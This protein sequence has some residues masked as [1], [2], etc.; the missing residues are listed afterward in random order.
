MNDPNRPS[1]RSRL[2]WILAVVVVVAGLVTAVVVSQLRSTTAGPPTTTATTTTALTT[3]AASA[4]ATKPTTTTPAAGSGYQLLWPFADEK[5]AADWQVSYREGGHQPWHLDAGQTAQSF[6]QGYLG[7]HSLDQIT[8]MTVAGTD[9]R[10]GVGYR[11]PGGRQN[12]AALLHLVKVGSGQD[13]PWEVVGSDDVPGLTLTT[14]A[15]GATVSS[16][17]TVGG[18]I[19]GVDESLR[20]LVFRLGQEQPIGQAGGIPAGGQDAAWT[21]HVSFSAPTGSTLT[22]AV[23]TG[24]HIN[25]VERIAITGVRSGV[26]ATG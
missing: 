7:Y 6:T 3:T 16:P 4:L 23:S 14:P 1:P 11:T 25:D 8:A 2:W 24:G 17:M 12:T 22:V 26:T 15:Y 21:A 9:A 10:V 13:A 18:R 20:V 19:T 5:E